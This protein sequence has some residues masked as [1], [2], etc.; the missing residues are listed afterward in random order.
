ML[1]PTLDASKTQSELHPERPFVSPP[2][3]LF[4][5]Y[6]DAKANFSNA[7]RSMQQKTWEAGIRSGPDLTN[8]PALLALLAHDGET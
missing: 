6:S 2:L 3:Q 1:R 5:P 4:P 8:L 7:E